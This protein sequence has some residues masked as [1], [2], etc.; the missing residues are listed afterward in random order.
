SRETLNNFPNVIPVKTGIQDFNGIW[1]PAFAGKTLTQVFPGAGRPN[2]LNGL[3]Y[4]Q[5]LEQP[6][7]K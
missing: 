1:F 2:T 5:L 6:Y 4:H 3:Q 7:G